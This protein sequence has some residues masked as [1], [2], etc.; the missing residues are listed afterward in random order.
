MNPTRKSRSFVNSFTALQ[1][2]IAMKVEKV[3]IGKSSRASLT[4]NKPTYPMQCD[5]PGIHPLK[6]MK[7]KTDMLTT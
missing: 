4:A 1:V 3:G 5:Q 2:L 6:R 7:N